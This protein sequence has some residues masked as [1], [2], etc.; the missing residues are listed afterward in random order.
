MDAADEPARKSSPPA[1]APSL[2][3][4]R[5]P[6]ANAAKEVAAEPLPL[7]GDDGEGERDDDGGGGDDLPRFRGEGVEASIEPAEAAAATAAN[8]LETTGSLALPLPVIRAPSTKT[9]SLASSM[10]LE[11]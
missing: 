5:A 4:A 10:K 7:P 2:A 3:A 11:L 9:Y 8:G 1:A 6:P